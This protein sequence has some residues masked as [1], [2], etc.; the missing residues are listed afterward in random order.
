M[1]YTVSKRIILLI[2]LT[3]SVQAN[4]FEMRECLQSSF[5]TEVKH[6]G[7]PFGLQEVAIRIDKKQCLIKIF[8]RQ[9]KYFKKAW[10]VDVCRSPIHVKKGGDSVEVIKKSKSCGQGKKDVFCSEYAHIAKRIQDDGLIF[11]SGQKEDI[12][13]DHGKFNCV[14]TMINEYFGK[15]VVFSLV[16][17][18][19]DIQLS[20]KGSKEAPSQEP[21]PNNQEAQ[22]QVPSEGQPADF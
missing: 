14:F 20:Y 21:M 19:N 4:S 17:P 1:L 13:T 7:W 16:E 18:T 10:T 9:F 11:A 12:G 6:N 3:L 15:G 8:H 22:G 2:T 5:N